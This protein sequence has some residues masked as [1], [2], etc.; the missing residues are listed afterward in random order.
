MFAIGDEEWTGLSKLLE[1]AGEVIQIGGKLMGSRGSTNHWS[2]DIRTRLIDEIADLMGAITFFYE[3]NF[4]DDELY[5]MSARA[6]EKLD[7]FYEWHETN[8]TL[9][10]SD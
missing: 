3:K 9:P 8:P 10:K 4:S 6:K 1:E 7:M 2:G 5:S